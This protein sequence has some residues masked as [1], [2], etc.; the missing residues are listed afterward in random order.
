[1]P[2]QSQPSLAFGSYLDGSQASP[3]NS[4]LG[5]GFFD[6]HFRP[7]A[8]E[9]FLHQMA[10]DDLEGVLLDAS[11]RCCSGPESPVAIRVTPLE[12][13]TIGHILDPVG[14]L[15]FE[16]DFL[17]A[18]G[19]SHEMAHDALLAGLNGAY[20]VFA[21]SAYPAGELGGEVFQFIP[22]PGTG[23]LSSL[24][25]ATLAWL[26]RSDR[27]RRDRSW[28]R[29]PAPVSSAKYRSPA[30]LRQRAAAAAA[31]LTARRLP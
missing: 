15:S 2:S 3:P 11:V 28:S 6:F 7:R 17:A 16:P 12:P 5:Y 31:A 1:M 26:R 27:E 25:L 22:E 9:I 19:G 21:T 8:H 23:T 14:N 10:W 24:G 13:T 18:H 29:F 30:L 20:I 4:S